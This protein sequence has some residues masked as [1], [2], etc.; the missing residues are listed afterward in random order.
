V[1]LHGGTIAATSP[2]GGGT[3]IEV[4]LPATVPS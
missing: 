3:R 4:R 1:E 2:P